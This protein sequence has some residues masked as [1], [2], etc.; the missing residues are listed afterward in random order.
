MKYVIAKTGKDIVFSSE[1]H[2]MF[3]LELTNVVWMRTLGS[4]QIN[5]DM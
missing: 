2:G 5:D 4:L 1:L 3:A